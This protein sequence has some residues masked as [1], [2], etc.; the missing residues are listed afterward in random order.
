MA[1]LIPPRLSAKLPQELRALH[2]MLKKLPDDFQV[3]FPYATSTEQEKPQVFALWRGKYGFLI[4]VAETSQKLAESAI[5]GDL[6]SSPETSITADSIGTTEGNILNNFTS[7]LLHDLGP[8]SGSLTVRKIVVFPN[9]REHTIDD[10]AILRGDNQP[11]SY[12][13][14]RQ[15]DPARFARYLEALAEAALPDPVIHHL[16]CRMT[17]ESVVPN[18]FNARAPVDRPTATPLLPA[19][20]DF[21]QEWCVK[22]DLELLPEQ[23][24]LIEQQTRTKLITGVAGSGKSLVLLYRALLF[25]KENPTARCLVLTHNKALIHELQ[26]RAEHLNQGPARIQCRTFFSWAGSELRQSNSQTIWFPDK[27]LSAVHDLRNQF[28]SLA[29]FSPTYLVDEIGW[30]KDQGIL[31]KT[32]YLSADRKGRAIPLRQNQLQQLWKFFKTYQELLRDKQATDWHNIAI[33]FHKAAITLNQLNFPKFDAIFIDEAQFFAKTWFEI[34]KAALRP[35]GHLFLAADPTQGF[36]RRRQS[37]ISAGINVIGRTTR[38][39]TAYRNTRAILSFARNFYQ[40]RTSSDDEIDLNIPNDETLANIPTVGIDPEILHANSP[41]DELALAVNRICQLKK[42]NL[43]NGCI[44]LIDTEPF[45]LKSLTTLL[46]KQLGKSAVH[47]ASESKRPAAAFCSLATINT[48]TGLEAPVVILIGMDQL[49][50][51]ENDPTLSAEETSDLRRDNTRRLYMAIT[52][53]GQ[54][55]IITRTSPNPSR[56]EF[57]PASQPT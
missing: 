18:T 10:L 3:W 6:F 51:R 27:I 5:H 42:Q 48:A 36:L 53:A 43:A 21:D 22:N 54:R 12:L 24:S 32:S 2:G 13:G 8:L 35:N 9:V 30:I 28:T 33:R 11:I 1:K 26:R 55:L 40:E 56:S 23:Q 4:Q 52:R 29:R 45:R 49:I 44:L 41:Q 34:V 37:W 25:L 39:S 19:F 20:L 31:S 16:R 14:L 46:S 47:L 15:T 50:A 57:P 7:S 17:P 38:L